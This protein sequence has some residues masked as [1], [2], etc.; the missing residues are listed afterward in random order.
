MDQEGAPTII[1]LEEGSEWRFELENDEN[2]AV[3]VSA[4]F[5]VF[6]SFSKGQSVRGKSS[7]QLSGLS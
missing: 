3:R 6:E 7:R 5:T 1:D 2:I 4:H